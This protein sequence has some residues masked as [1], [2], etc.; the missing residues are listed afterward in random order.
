MYT[1]KLL[2]NNPKRNTSYNKSRPA[3]NE[4]PCLFCDKDI[5][6]TYLLNKTKL[7]VVRANAYPFIDGAILLI[8]RRHIEFNPE[9][10]SKE[11]I[12][13]KSHMD[14]LAKTWTEYYLKSS[15]RNNKI[16]IIDEGQVSY[17]YYVNN[18]PF[19]GQTQR[20]LHWHFIPRMYRVTTAMEEIEP[21]KK[22]NMTPSETVELFKKGY[23]R[24]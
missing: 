18:G 4:E 5:L 19:S 10:T 15:K 17:N 6:N 11:W 9:L 21:F 24:G 13:L 14:I 2:V 12:E 16:Q 1:K 20:H 3:L 23:E 22:V 7:W 8:P